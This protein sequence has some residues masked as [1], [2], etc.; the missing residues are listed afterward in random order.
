M[1]AAFW[2]STTV[3]EMTTAVTGLMSRT[4]VRIIHSFLLGY[5]S[6]EMPLLS[7]LTITRNNYF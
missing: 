4:V 5:N 3:M 2:T 6:V 1:V 7:I